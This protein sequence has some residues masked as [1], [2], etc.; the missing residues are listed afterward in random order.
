MVK[1]KKILGRSIL[2]EQKCTEITVTK[3]ILIDTLVKTISTIKANPL[4]GFEE[5]SL[6]ALFLSYF[7]NDF[8]SYRI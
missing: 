3:T 8:V 1:K 2:T 6:Y 5:I 4:V 7:Y